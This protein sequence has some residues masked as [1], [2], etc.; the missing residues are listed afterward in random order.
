LLIS[1]LARFLHLGRSDKSPGHIPAANR[2]CYFAW[3][4]LQRMLHQHITFGAIQYKQFNCNKVDQIK[5]LE[6]GFENPIDAKYCSRCGY[7]LPVVPVVEVQEVSKRKKRVLS[8]AERRKRLLNVVVTMMGVAIGSA[9]VR[10]F[11]NPKPSIDKVLLVATSEWNKNC[12]FMVDNQT[13]MDNAIAL[14]DHT[15]QYNYSLVR[16]DA[17]QIDTAMFHQAMEPGVI[18]A[19]KTNPQMKLFREQKVQ[20]VYNYRDKKGI[21]IAKLTVTPDMYAE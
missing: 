6:C 14:P 7:A 21:Y 12:P 20:F 8:K 9:G 13:R 19:I 5:R 2:L 10:M 17:R 18:N 16:L 3:A 11:V 4:F 15:V 1:H